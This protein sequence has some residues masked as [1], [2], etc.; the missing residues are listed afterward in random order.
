MGKETNGNE[1]VTEAK[2]QQEI[3][4]WYR[5]SFCLNFHYPKHIIFSVPNESSKKMDTLFKMA[6][7]MVPG[8]SDMIIVR[9]DEVLFVEVKRPGQKQSENQINFQNDVE[10]LGY[11]YILTHSLEEFKNQINSK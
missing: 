3:Y 5:N 7:G 8:V 4:C 9:P 1:N 6:R 2:I 10:K 11:R